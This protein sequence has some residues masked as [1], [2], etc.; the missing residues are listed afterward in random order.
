MIIDIRFLVLCETKFEILYFAKS[1][2][3]REPHTH[4][5]TNRKLLEKYWI[6]KCDLFVSDTLYFY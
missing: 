5:Q 2:Q 4:T 3:E 1:S 6:V